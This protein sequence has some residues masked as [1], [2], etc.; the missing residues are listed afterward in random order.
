MILN[1][2]QAGRGIEYGAR[3]YSRL[4]ASDFTM[5]AATHFQLMNFDGM[6]NPVNCMG[7]LPVTIQLRF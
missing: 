4:T 2:I 6:L 7:E 3:W 1:H 5:A